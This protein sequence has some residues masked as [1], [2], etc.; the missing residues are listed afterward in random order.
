MRVFDPRTKAVTYDTPDVEAL[1]FDWP[2]LKAAVEDFNR[3]KADLE[4]TASKVRELNESRQGA[5]D[6]DQRALA[7]A[8]RE[9]KADPGEQ[10]TAKVDAEIRNA[11]RRRDALRLAIQEQAAAITSVID[12]HRSKWRSEVSD[13]LPATQD[14]LEAAEREVAA[15]RSE[16]EGLH[17][18]AEWLREP[19]K[20]YTPKEASPNT[21]VVIQGGIHRQSA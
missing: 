1:G 11:E 8:I 10:H 12:E 2:E 7:A 4:R 20:P 3:L 18:L 19:S 9:G 6:Q 13:R 15:T 14:R 17:G 16:L 5:E 21:T